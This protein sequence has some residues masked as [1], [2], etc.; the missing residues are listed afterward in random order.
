MTVR[1]RPLDGGGAVAC[2]ASIITAG[3]VVWFDCRSVYVSDSCLI[4]TRG[5][6]IYSGAKPCF[7]ACSRKLFAKYCLQS[8]GRSNQKQER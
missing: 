4:S 5:G 7:S 1:L 3:Y 6:S 2:S 8:D